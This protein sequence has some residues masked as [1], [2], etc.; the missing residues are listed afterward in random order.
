MPRDNWR[1]L[2]YVEPLWVSGRQLRRSG[3]WE[4]SIDA[5]IAKGR[6]EQPLLDFRVPVE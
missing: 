2:G 3:Y 4:S 6:I 5:K 1:E